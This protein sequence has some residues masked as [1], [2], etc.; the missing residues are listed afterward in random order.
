MKRFFQASN[1]QISKFSVHIKNGVA[2]ACTNPYKRHLNIM[3]SAK[4][5]L[6][7]LKV[8]M[9]HGYTQNGPLFHAKTRAMEKHLQKIFPGILLIYPTAPLQLKPSDVPGF[10]S[11]TNEDPESIEAYG[12]WRRSDTSNPPEYYGLDKGLES[13]AEI[14]ESEGPFD[15]VIGFS[16]G[17]ALAAMIA[18]LLEGDSRK[19]AFAKA[20]GKSKLAIP[21]PRAFENLGHPPFKFCAAYSG[22]RAPGER[23]TAFFE[24]PHI[25]T[26][27]CHFIGSLD[28]VVEEARTQ[29]L[30]DAAGGEKRTQVVVHPGGHFVP[31]GKQYLDTIAAF[32]KQTT[33]SESRQNGNVEERV[34]DMDVP[35]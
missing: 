32:I 12:W 27:M 18:S 7:S 8:L 29:A 24:E 16:Q 23:Y 10:N 11:T 26:P 5:P 33:T 25:Q 13:V 21:F 30:V 28:S 4:E 22:F 35:F 17:A 15:G 34:E 1:C 19:E 9:L 6:P 14:L 3:P 20:Q 2:T 31:S